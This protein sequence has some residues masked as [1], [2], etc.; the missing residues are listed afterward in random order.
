MDAIRRHILG[1]ATSAAITLAALRL[2]TPNIVDLMI[3]GLSVGLVWAAVRLA[4]HD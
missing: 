1:Y 2:I 3:D 4:R